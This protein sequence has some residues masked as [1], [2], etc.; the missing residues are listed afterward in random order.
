MR[1]SIS[2]SSWSAGKTLKCKKI[3][4]HRNGKTSFLVNYSNT[5]KIVLLGSPVTSVI[6]FFD[7]KK[8][9]PVY[10]DPSGHFVFY[11]IFVAHT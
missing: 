1:Y 11:E 7:L 6:T 4:S 10:I 9:A 5:F 8:N 3:K 2:Y